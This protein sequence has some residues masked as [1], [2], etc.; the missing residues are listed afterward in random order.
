MKTCVICKIEKDLSKF[1]KNHKSKDGYQHKCV[2]CKNKKIKK[3]KAVTYRKT[4]GLIVPKIPL[5]LTTNDGFGGY[6]K[7]DIEQIKDNK[8]MIQF[9]K[10]HGQYVNHKR[11]YQVKSND[12]SKLRELA[13]SLGMD[14]NCVIHIKREPNNRHLETYVLN[15]YKLDARKVLRV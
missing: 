13:D 14:A 15:L 4:R 7:Y 12:L 3:G 9:A 5:K 11:W 10:E 1:K 2:D 8:A 6:W